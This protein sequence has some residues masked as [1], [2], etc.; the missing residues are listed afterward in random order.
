MGVYVETYS[1]PPMG[2][3][4]NVDQLIS[5]ALDSA[6]ESLAPEAAYAGGGSGTREG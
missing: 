6:P 4:S 5:D 3:E 1:I 2:I